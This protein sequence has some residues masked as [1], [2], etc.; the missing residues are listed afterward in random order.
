[1]KISFDKILWSLFAFF[2]CAA[3]YFTIG[4]E[5]FKSRLNVSAENL[6]F[7]SGQKVNVLK[8]IDGDE[9]SVK[10]DNAQFIVR[11]LGISSY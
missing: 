6:N 9:I 4:V 2:L 10:M 7:S 8:V 5:R 11:I 3:L 1:M